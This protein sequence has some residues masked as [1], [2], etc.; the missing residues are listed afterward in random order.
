MCGT[1]VYLITS[2]I[3]S[4][5][6]IVYYRALDDSLLISINYTR[7]VYLKHYKDRTE[8]WAMGSDTDRIESYFLYIGYNKTTKQ[9][10]EELLNNLKENGKKVD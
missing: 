9:K 3:M 1:R 4:K 7:L 10:F 2:N 5:E 6:K 8:R